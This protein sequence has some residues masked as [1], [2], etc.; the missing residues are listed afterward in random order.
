M[1]P[2]KSCGNS[3]AFGPEKLSVFHLKHLGHR[4][5]EL[6][7]VLFNTERGSED[8]YWMSQDVQYRSPTH[9]GRNAEVKEHTGLLSAQY[10]AICLKPGNVCHPITRATPERQMKETLYT[11]SRHC[12]ANDGKT[13]IGKLHSKHSTLLHSLRLF[14]VT[15]G[16]W[17]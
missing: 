17:C 3:K 15:R 13:M 2:I 7:T 11:T 8:R 5:I 10:L 6:N 12:R 16:M 1:R 14:S 4:A 9:R